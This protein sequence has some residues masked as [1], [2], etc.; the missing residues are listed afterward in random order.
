M[1]VTCQKIVKSGEGHRFVLQQAG[2]RVPGAVPITGQVIAGASFPKD[3][4]SIIIFYE[5]LDSDTQYGGSRW[6]NKDI[7]RTHMS[8]ELSASRSLFPR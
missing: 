3:G 2:V 8:P 6:P 5:S 7:G 1:S 4:Y